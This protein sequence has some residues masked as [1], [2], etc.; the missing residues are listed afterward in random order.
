MSYFTLSNG[1]KLYFE[2]TQKGDQTIIKKFSFCCTS[3][4]GKVYAN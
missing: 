3:S 4:K 1:E 2:D